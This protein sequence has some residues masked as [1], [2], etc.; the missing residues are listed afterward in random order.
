MA[1]DGLTWTVT[2]GQTTYI[3]TNAKNTSNCKL[4]ET[5]AKVGTPCGY[6]ASTTQVAAVISESTLASI[7]KVEVSGD[8]DT[9]NPTKI[10]LVYST[11]NTTYTLVETQDYSKAN[12]NTFVF[13]AKSA[14]YYA[15]VLYY[16]G[17]SYMSTNNLKIKFYKAQ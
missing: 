9:Y 7:G 17:N 4:G 12:G 3:G 8:T 5:Y 13:D 6:S 10:S 15:V 14:G 1:S 2:Y 16:D 11:D